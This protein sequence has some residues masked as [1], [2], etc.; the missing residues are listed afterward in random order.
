[1]PPAVIIRRTLMVIAHRHK[2]AA[3]IMR[4]SRRPLG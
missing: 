2:V 1:M 4:S 3:T